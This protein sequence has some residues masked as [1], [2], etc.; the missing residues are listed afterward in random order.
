MKKILSLILFLS[1]TFGAFAKDIDGTWKTSIQGPEGDFELTY[2][3]K[4]K[5]GK[6]TGAIQTPFGNTEITNTK[7]NNKEFSFEVA[8]NEMVIKYNCKIN[9]DGTITAKVTGTPMGDT[10]QILKRKD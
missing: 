1:L 5:D 9:D 3:F 7:L 4:T 6:L 10:E 8:F 2:V